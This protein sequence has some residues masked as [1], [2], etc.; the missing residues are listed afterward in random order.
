VPTET[1]EDFRMKTARQGQQYHLA[2]DL[3][4]EIE[5]EIAELFE[6]Q[7]GGQQ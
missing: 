6:K 1:I 2:L 4:D 5:E 7:N 3:P